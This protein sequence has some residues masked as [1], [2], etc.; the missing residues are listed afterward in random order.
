MA[1]PLDWPIL[2]PAGSAPK[3]NNSKPFQLLFHREC[4]LGPTSFLTGGAW[5][6]VISGLHFLHLIPLSCRRPKE[7]SGH[8]IHKSHGALST[9]HKYLYSKDIYESEHLEHRAEYGDKYD[10]DHSNRPL[11]HI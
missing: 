10:D 9:S 6:A 4:F 1:W 2:C 7:S 11:A 8:E 5:K 3:P